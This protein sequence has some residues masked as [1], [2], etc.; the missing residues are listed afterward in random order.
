MPSRRITPLQ[1]PFLSSEMSMAIGLPSSR[2][3][4]TTCADSAS[5]VALWARL[6][7]SRPDRSV[8]LPEPAPEPE[9][10]FSSEP[11]PEG[12]GAVAPAEARAALPMSAAWWPPTGRHPVAPSRAVV[13][14]AVATTVRLRM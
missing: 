3:L 4:A 10:L 2:T 14:I 12:A 9:P 7:I 1:L 5:R 11:E 8:S 6:R 13:P